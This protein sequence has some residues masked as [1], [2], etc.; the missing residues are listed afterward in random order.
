[1]P[2]SR[3]PLDLGEP[4]QK[5]WEEFRVAFAAAFQHVWLLDELEQIA[6]DYIANVESRFSI[7]FLNAEGLAAENPEY[8]GAVPVQDVGDRRGVTF[9][10]RHLANLL[11]EQLFPNDRNEADHRSHA[12]G[13]A[14]V[15][16]HAALE[17][18]ATGLRPRVR[19]RWQRCATSQRRQSHELLHRAF[20]QFRS[21]QNFHES[22]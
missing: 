11:Y 6:P 7:G 8:D 12:Y 16:V 2:V 10:D 3:D 22:E 17:S 13:L 19:R 18:Y 21:R 5:A 14:L 20:G 1:M 9:Y 4:Q 15:G